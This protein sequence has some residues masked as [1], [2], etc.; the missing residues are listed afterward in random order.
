MQVY[1]SSSK[2]F[3]EIGVSDFGYG[4]AATLKRNPQFG[5]I[6]SDSQAIRLASQ[7]GTSEFDDPT[8]G[9]GL[10]HLLEI[11]FKHEGSVQIWSGGA[12]RRFRM[13]QRKGWEFTVPNLP[14]VHVAMTLRSKT[15]KRARK[16][17]RK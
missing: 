10:F 3:L 1:Q 14:G 16:G 6:S 11:A 17:G 8:R 13:D 2:R 15:S 5:S 9:T 7:L 4:I 12:K